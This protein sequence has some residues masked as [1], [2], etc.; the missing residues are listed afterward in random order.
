[1]K[2]GFLIFTVAI[3]FMCILFSA[4]DNIIDTGKYQKYYEFPNT[5]EW[6]L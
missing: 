5:V 3:V 1:M 6:T 4:C 2:K